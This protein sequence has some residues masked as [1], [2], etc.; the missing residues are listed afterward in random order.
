MSRN[1]C[2]QYVIFA[3]KQ[4]FY[5]NNMTCIQSTV[6]IIEQKLMTSD[7]NYNKSQKQKNK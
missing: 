7:K 2:C 6:D 3:K 5:H 1:N 4:S